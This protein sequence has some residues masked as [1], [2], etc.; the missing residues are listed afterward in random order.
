VANVIHLLGD[1]VSPVRRLASVGLVLH[2]LVH[3]LGLWAGEIADAF[4]DGLRAE[5]VA[6]VRSR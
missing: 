5:P 1:L 6:E 3:L 4:C 2:R